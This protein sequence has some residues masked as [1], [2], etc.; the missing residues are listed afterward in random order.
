[1]LTFH[2]VQGADLECKDNDGQTPLLL[3][4][5]KCSWSVVNTLVKLGAS[6]DVKDSNNRNILH[7][8][9]RGGGQPAKFGICMCQ[10]VS[11]VVTLVIAAKTLYVNTFACDAGQF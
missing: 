9:I 10:K 1:M 5:A 8:I 11:S 7:L 4:A 2:V 6:I 3:A